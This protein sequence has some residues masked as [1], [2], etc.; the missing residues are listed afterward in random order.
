MAKA[1]KIKANPDQNHDF[2]VIFPETKVEETKQGRTLIYVI[3]SMDDKIE[4]FREQLRG[5]ISSIDIAM[6]NNAVNDMDIARNY[7]HK[8]L[9]FRD[10]CLSF[11]S[12]D[13]TVRTL[14][15]FLKKEVGSYKIYCEI[16][17]ALIQNKRNFKVILA[18]EYSPLSEPT[19]FFD[20]CDE[21]RRDYDSDLDVLARFYNIY[22][23]EQILTRQLER[24]V[25]DPD[26]VAKIGCKNSWKVSY[27]KDILCQMSKDNQFDNEIQIEEI[28]KMQYFRLK[29]F[30]TLTI[31]GLK[32][33][34]D[35]RVWILHEVVD[36]I[37]KYQACINKAKE[38]T[39]RC[40]D[41][42]KDRTRLTILAELDHSI[43]DLEVVLKEKADHY[44]ICRFGQG[45]IK[46]DIFDT[47]YK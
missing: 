9:R 10:F 35:L 16:Y 29:K 31:G 7:A 39:W 19:P 44:D 43:E 38:E 21:R 46:A 47:L 33:V 5:Q 6:Q 34:L 20:Y 8:T 23:A 26:M 45:L 28:L 15:A 22:N 14:K 36:W 40:S 12:P 30:Y 17:K 41:K 13:A 2:P 4:D 32:E 11:T 37:K 25:S 27:L 24:L 3:P 42:Y 1:S 18:N